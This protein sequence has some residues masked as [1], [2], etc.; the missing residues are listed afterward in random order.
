MATLTNHFL[1]SLRNYLTFSLNTHIEAPRS[2]ACAVLN[3]IRQLNDDT[4]LLGVLV[5]LVWMLLCVLLISQMLRSA[6][7]RFFIFGGKKLSRA[8]SNK[9]RKYFH[10][11]DEQMWWEVEVFFGG[12]D[13][14]P[15]NV[16][17]KQVS[18]SFEL[19]QSTTFLVTRKKEKKVKTRLE[20][21]N[22]SD[23][24]IT[25]GRRAKSLFGPQYRRS[26]EM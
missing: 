12:G 3:T 24:I 9:L 15:L 18:K 8:K 19:S 21:K 4:R 16:S 25:K 17:L 5:R 22:F 14:I 10:L 7:G 2:T 20:K 11:G 1:F 13:Q 26:L 6:P 23:W